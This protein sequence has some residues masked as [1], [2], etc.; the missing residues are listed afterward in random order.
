MASPALRPG[1]SRSFAVSSPQVPLLSYGPRRSEIPAARELTALS[2]EFVAKPEKARNAP[3]CLAGTIHGALGE[4]SGFAGCLVMVSD[5]EAR[6]ITV[7]T[8]WEGD[9]AQKCCKRSI[10]WVQALLASYVDR[11]LH[12]KTMLA[13]LPAVP[14]ICTEADPADGGFRMGETD[15]REENACVA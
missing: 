3:A 2:M 12:V 7:V 8:F 13:H 4:V 6:L 11:C 10:K 9:E 15:A 14:R 5:Q 1:N